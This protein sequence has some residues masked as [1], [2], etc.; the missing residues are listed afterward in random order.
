MM[1]DMPERIWA[2]NTFDSWS[3][4]D[5]RWN[6]ENTEYIRADIAE[7]RIREL[8]TVLKSASPVYKQTSDTL[9]EMGIVIEPTVMYYRIEPEIYA[10][11]LEQIL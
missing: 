7:S 10:K 8:E 3:T 2:S 4:S 9:G 6:G 1:S 5:E 11:A